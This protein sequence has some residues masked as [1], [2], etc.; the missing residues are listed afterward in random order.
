MK[1]NKG[2]TLIELLAV[3]VILG[4]L[5]S[6]SVVAVTK[7]KKK[8]DLENKLNVLS[9]IFTGA[10][11]YIADNPNFWNQTECKN[12]VWSTGT[13]HCDGFG[14]ITGRTLYV[15]D[16]L[17]YV[18]FDTTK[19]PEWNNRSMMVTICPSNSSK[20]E[21]GMF[22][23]T[24]NTDHTYNRNFAITDCGCEEQ[25]LKTNSL[26]FCEANNR[27]ENNRDENNRSAGWD[28]TGKYYKSD[29]K[30]DSSKDL[31]IENLNN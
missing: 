28:I 10:K 7:I 15:N 13:P 4:V 20:Y 24:Y 11:N 9:S 1:K 29:G 18:D 16:I 27:D 19:Y 25:S 2:F 22:Y 26:K 6:I 31:T 23:A 12:D 30:P 21:V 14:N 8:Q 17:N 3:I 5:L